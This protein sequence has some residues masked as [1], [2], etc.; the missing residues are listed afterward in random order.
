LVVRRKWM[1]E[2]G[3]SDLAMFNL[4]IDSKLN[5]AISSASMSRTWQRMELPLIAPLSVKK[6][7][8]TPVRF[9]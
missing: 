9:E 8:G 3:Y 7:T 5:A 2:A 4:A 1:D 6:N